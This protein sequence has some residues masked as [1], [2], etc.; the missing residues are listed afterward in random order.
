VKEN[1]MTTATAVIGA[2]FGDEGKGLLTD[3]LASRAPSRTLVVRANGGAQA[4]HTVVAPG[5]RRHVFGHV[6]SGALCGAPTLLSRFFVSNPL[7]LDKEWPALADLAPRLLVDGRSPVTTPF[8]MLVNQMVERSRGALRHGSCGVGFN[9]TIERSLLPEFRLTVGDLRYP[10][11]VEAKLDAIQRTYLPQRLSVLGL[12]PEERERAL[13][14]GSGLAEAFHASTRRFLSRADIVPDIEALTG[15][16]QVLF[17]GAQGLLLDEDHPWFPHVTRSKTG[18]KNIVSLLREAGLN[19]LRVVYATRWYLTRHG[20]GPFPTEVAGKPSPAIVDRT[21]LPNDWQG[22][23]R[24][25]LLD[26]EGLRGTI[27]ADRLSAAGMDLDVSLALTC[28]DQMGD[29]AEFIAEGNTRLRVHPRSA[30]TI[31]A[32]RTGLEVGF[33]SWGPMRA[34]VRSLAPARIRRAS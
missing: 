3:F 5:G 12:Q 32:E 21:N 20:A 27:R 31:L 13:L 24:F 15:F 7:L 26:L 28:L 14:E 8:D 10:E 2:N 19:R 29:R 6:G 30:A 25:G 16:E 33:T 9:E 34:D 17:E 22:T 11:T 23:L 4:G 1:H 18:L